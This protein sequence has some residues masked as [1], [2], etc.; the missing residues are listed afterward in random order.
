MTCYTK[1]GSVKGARIGRRWRQRR[2]GVEEER[3]VFETVGALRDL[4]FIDSGV[5]DR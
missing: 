1:K 3:R 4:V 2:Q 5:T